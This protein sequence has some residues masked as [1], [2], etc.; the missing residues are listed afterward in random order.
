[1]GF[2]VQNIPKYR[3]HFADYVDGADSADK[4]INL[5]H[6]SNLRKLRERDYE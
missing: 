3:L 2:I 1:M 6:F 4:T 5:R